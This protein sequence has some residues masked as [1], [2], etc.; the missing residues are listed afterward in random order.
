MAIYRTRALGVLLVAL[1]LLGAVVFGWLIWRDKH[2]RLESTVNDA[3][4]AARASCPKAMLIRR[5]RA[6]I[7]IAGCGMVW[8]WER[9][10]SGISCTW[11]VTQIGALGYE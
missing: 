8:V 4:S 7:L 11:R 5:T 1:V 3:V 10:C 2:R 6:R 9:D